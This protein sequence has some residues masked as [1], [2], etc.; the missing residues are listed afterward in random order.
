MRNG[1]IDGGGGARGG[2][3][4]GRGGSVAQRTRKVAIWLRKMAMARPLTKPSITG[5]G[6]SRMYFPRR[7]KPAPICI[8]PAPRGGHKGSQVGHKGVVRGSR[9]AHEGEYRSS[10]DAR[11]PQNPPKS[12]GYQR[13]LRGVLYSTRGAHTSVRN[14][15][16]P[17]L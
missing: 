12:E 1:P 3:R 6:T 9:E 15:V 8:M 17:T 4:G 14:A 16:L 11:E 13:H 10:V 5:W 7:M 2:R